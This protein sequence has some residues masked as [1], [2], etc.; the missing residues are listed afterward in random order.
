V[1]SL[2]DQRRRAGDA[3][4]VAA[5][6]D[7]SHLALDLTNMYW[8]LKI[9]AYTL[10]E[11]LY[12]TTDLTYLTTDQSATL[13][14]SDKVALAWASTTRLQRLLDDITSQL[15][16][17]SDSLPTSYDTAATIPTTGAVTNAIDAFQASLTAACGSDISD[18]IGGQMHRIVDHIK[19][20]K[21]SFLIPL[22]STT[23]TLAGNAAM[24]TLAGTIPG[25]IGTPAQSICELLL[26]ANESRRRG[27]NKLLYNEIVGLRMYF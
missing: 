2:L 3:S 10:F 20:M 25:T 19:D 26:V 15:S 18:L 27:S 8:N 11:C 16:V 23:Q 6:A 14:T 4:A 12:F 21:T 24:A 13:S 17:T 9:L 5:F 22:Q 1:T 7:I